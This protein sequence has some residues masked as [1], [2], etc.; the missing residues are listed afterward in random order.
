MGTLYDFASKR[1]HPNT[2]HVIQ[3]LYITQQVLELVDEWKYIWTYCA[4]HIH[5]NSIPVGN[6][7]GYSITKKFPFQ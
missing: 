5:V 1:L 2:H 6:V 3:G 4:F 7:Y